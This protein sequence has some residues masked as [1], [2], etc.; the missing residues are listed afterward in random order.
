MRQ[1]RPGRNLQGAG[2]PVIYVVHIII[3]F[4]Y[5]C[6]LLGT[7]DFSQVTLI[8]ILN[9]RSISSTPSTWLICN[10]WR[11]SAKKTG[12]LIIGRW[13]GEVRRK[14]ALLSLLN[15]VTK[16]S[17][18]NFEVSYISYLRQFRNKISLESF[19]IISEHQLANWKTP[20][21]KEIDFGS[22]SKT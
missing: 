10:S 21:R 15:Q 3:F 12:Y 13:V 5:T 2:T 18:N 9:T 11:Q 16:M 20:Q 1:E 17:W 19:P 14:V 8:F 6:Y 4:W 22:S 7:P